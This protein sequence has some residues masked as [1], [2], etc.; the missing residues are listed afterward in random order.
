MIFHSEMN[1]DFTIG[2]IK[3][4]L[5]HGVSIVPIYSFGETDLYTHSPFLLHFRRKLSKRLST[6]FVLLHGPSKLFPLRA[7]P[8]IELNQVFGTPI[9]VKKTPNPTEEDIEKL[10][11]K[12]V[13]E[14]QRIF[15]KYKAQFG[16][17]QCELVIH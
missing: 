9:P 15:N 16:Y 10:H 1:L 3:L 13:N 11:A 5:K 6:A 4:A 7:Y 12:Y 17:E 14:L 8:G 2:H